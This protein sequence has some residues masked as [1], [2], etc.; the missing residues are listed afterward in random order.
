M[1]PG[2]L[3]ALVA[4]CGSHDDIACW[5]LA[6]ALLA[7]PEV[8]E[9]VEA[10]WGLGFER[11]NCA[12]WRGV[13]TR[14]PQRIE[15]ERRHEAARDAVADI[16]DRLHARIAAHLTGYRDGYRDGRAPGRA[17]ALLDVNRCMTEVSDVPD[18][19][20]ALVTQIADTIAKADRESYATGRAAGLR[21]AAE[22]S[23]LVEVEADLS[24]YAAAAIALTYGDGYC[25]GAADAA[26]AYRARILALLGP[27]EVES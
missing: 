14:P 6:K 3:R 13:L 26:E 8:V 12:K 4:A 22:M 11:A 15:D 7:S 18:D 19:C 24:D 17:S 9:A 10:I 1:K 21:E 16:A 20:A 5:V 23:R 2:E 25:A 27:G